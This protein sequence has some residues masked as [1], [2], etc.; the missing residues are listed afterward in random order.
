M[1]QEQSDTTVAASLLYLVDRPKPS[2]A[3]TGGSPSASAPRAVTIA[4]ARAIDGLSLEREGFLLVRH[5]SA[6]ANFYDPEEVRRVYY[7]ELVSL[8]KDVT[9]AS[10]VAIFAHDVRSSDQSKQDGDRVREPVSSVHNDYTPVSGPQ[11]VRATLP[12]DE[13][14][15]RLD[16]RFVELNIW[17]PIRG[18]VLT[19]P[20]AVC[21]A[22]SIA[23]ADLVPTDR[24]LKHE[25]FM[26][27]FNPA[28]RWFYF[29]RMLTGE[30]LL[31]KGFDSMLDGRA[32]F[33]A[34]ASFLDPTTPPGAPPRE[35]IEAR[36]LLFW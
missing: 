8:L 3:D 19:R 1:P 27:T 22:R 29:P 30:T 16:K 25:V 4:N 21:D 31:I 23:P 36:A 6:V 13:A 10:K 15:H 14:A 33:T 17:K 18:P 28:H 11:M 32:R 20:L 5:H 2:R 9:G 7:P 26:L 34:H 12:A 35:S 24:Y